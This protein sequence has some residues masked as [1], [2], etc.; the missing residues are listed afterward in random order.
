MDTEPDASLKISLYENK[1]LRQVQIQLL[2]NISN[3]FE[4]CKFLKDEY[5]GAPGDR[6][7]PNSGRDGAR[8]KKLHHNEE[9]LGQ[10]TCMGFDRTSAKKALKLTGDV[11]NAVT[12][13]LE[14][15]EAGLAEVSDSEEEERKRAE[16]DR[17]A[18]EARKARAE[19]AKRKAE[20][21]R[22]E[23]QS[24]LIEVADFKKYLSKIQEKG[25][26]IVAQWSKFSVEQSKVIPYETQKKY[27]RLF[28]SYVLNLA[29]SPSKNEKDLTEIFDTVF[30][31]FR[32]KVENQLEQGVQSSSSSV[33]AMIVKFQDTKNLLTLLNRLIRLAPFKP[34]LSLKSH[35]RQ[36]K[37]MDA[38]QK[39]LKAITSEASGA[40]MQK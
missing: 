15:G 1:D 11:S 8:P 29:K 36:H 2:Q 32:D 23:R 28:E 5:G 22:K 13:L 35:E 40:S 26:A 4:K 14:S 20:E 25:L 19:E 21:L 16:E 39:T 27:W 3:G 24:K 38:V 31:Q 18:E 37:L 33:E 9:L 17:L 6:N 7:K 12:F 30:D 34:I 10:I